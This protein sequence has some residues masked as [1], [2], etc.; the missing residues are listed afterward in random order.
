MKNGEP[1]AT[2]SNCA[3]DNCTGGFCQ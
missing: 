2:N 1:C 3:S